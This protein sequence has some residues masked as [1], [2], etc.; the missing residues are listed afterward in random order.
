MVL[1]LDQK[2]TRANPYRRLVQTRFYT[3]PALVR[4]PA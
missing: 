3:I 2:E 1:L 4:Y